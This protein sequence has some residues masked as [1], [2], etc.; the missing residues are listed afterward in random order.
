SSWELLLKLQPCPVN[1][2]QPAATEPGAA[3]EV[4]LLLDIRGPDR[5]CVG[6]RKRGK[7]GLVCCIAVRRSKLGE[8]LGVGL[9]EN[10]FL[11]GKK[12]AGKLAFHLLEF[13]W[14]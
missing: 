6:C 2:D 4:G 8:I 1:F 13:L 7:E 11:T 12:N 5:F 9:D 14:R 10:H 3:A